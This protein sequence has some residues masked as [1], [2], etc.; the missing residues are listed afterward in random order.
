MAE[1]R[2]PLDHVLAE[3]VGKPEEEVVAWWRHRF[4]Q[5]AAIPSATARAGALVP[6]WREL[7]MLPAPACSACCS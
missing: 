7:A 5:I 4:E 3:Q 1:T 2:R 6:E